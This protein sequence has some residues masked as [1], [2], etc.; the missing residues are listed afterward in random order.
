MASITVEMQRVE[1]PKRALNFEVASCFED[2][3]KRSFC[4]GQVGDGSGGVKAIWGR[5]EV[6]DDI[7]SEICLCKIVGGVLASAVLEKVKI[8]HA[9]TKVGPF[10]PRLIKRLNRTFQN[11]RPL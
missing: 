10:E 11:C 7:I 4:D 6:V 5:P 9:H 3:P 2:F 1:I 8:S